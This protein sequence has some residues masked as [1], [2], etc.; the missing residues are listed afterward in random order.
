MYQLNLTLA[1]GASFP[2]RSTLP[3]PSLDGEIV[4][5]TAYPGYSQ[6]ISDPSYYGQILVFAFPC[7]GLYGLDEEDLQSSRPWV[8]AVI[9]GRIEDMDGKVQDWLHRW[10]VPILVGID[11][12]SLILRIREIGTSM[13]RVSKVAER[14]LIDALG[15]DLVHQV[16]SKSSKY[17][18][19]G[20]ISLALI[21]YGVKSDIV[22]RLVRLGCNVT[23]LPHMSS[24]A[25]ILNGGFDGVL[26]SNGPGDP[27]ELSEEV[28]VIR[29][30]IGRIPVFGICLGCQLLALACG[31]KTQRLPYGHRGS[32]H[33]VVEEKSGHAIITSQNHGYAIY[34][35]SLDGTGLEVIFRHLADGTVEGVRHTETGAW[36][37]QFHPEA[38]AGP[39]DGLSL[40][41]RFIDQIKEAQFNG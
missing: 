34:E 12:R 4:F 22:R 30:L 11:C 29:D 16:S 5:T 14:P 8:K 15:G 33:P 26:L 2:C 1:D 17:F 28:S 19:A 32:N 35:S 38:G 21:D 41:D 27:S 39:L 13:A 31:A 18:G 7:I 23:V 10:D 6:S 20:D 3:S 9:I 25:T 40:F 37:V 24:A 36:G